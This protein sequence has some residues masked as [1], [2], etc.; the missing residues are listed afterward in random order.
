MGATGAGVPMPSITKR[1]KACNSTATP[2][3][4]SSAPA[5]RSPIHGSAD[6]QPVISQGTSPATTPGATRRNTTLP[7]AALTRDRMHGQFYARCASTLCSS[8]NA[9]SPADLAHHGLRMAGEPAPGVAQ[10][11]KAGSYQRGVALP[12]LLKRS[13]GVVC[14][15][16]VE[17][18]HHPLRPPKAVDLVRSSHQHAASHSSPAPAPAPAG[19]TLGS[20]APARCARR[21][22]GRWISRASSRLVNRRRPCARAIAVSI[23]ARSS[24]RR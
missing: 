18:H 9:Q 12:I 1:A 24:R 19:T 20:G 22:A 15:R 10:G 7:S 2:A 17:L 4:M 8:I 21:S 14:R 3:A 5:N 23:A 6:R 16:T 13:R 11:A